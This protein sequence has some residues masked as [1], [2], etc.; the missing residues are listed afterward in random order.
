MRV[1]IVGHP[2]SGTTYAGHCFRRTAGWKVGHETPQADGVSSW[3]WAVRS[4]Y[5]PN[6]K[7]RGDTPLP[8]AVLHILREPARCVSSVRYVEGGSENWRRNFI[9]I[10]GTECGA[11]ERAVWSIYGWTRLIRE[12]THP[13]HVAQTERV[14]R[15][16][17]QITGFEELGVDQYLNTQPHPRL[18][19]DQI[20]AMTWVYP[21]TAIMWDHI[22]ADYEEAAQ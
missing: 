16:V 20:K 4:W 9:K 11:V 12:N 1:L 2:R 22:Q 17:A 8:P 15:A 13:T 3:M 18:S 7:P 21:E 10:P 19:A 14:E 6:G 5:S